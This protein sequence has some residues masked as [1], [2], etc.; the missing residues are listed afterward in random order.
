MAAVEMTGAGVLPRPPP[1]TLSRSGNA[2]ETVNSVKANI[3]K[4][5]I[6]VMM[7]YPVMEK[8]AKYTGL[9]ASGSE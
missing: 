7:I 4:I 9:P 6:L 3:K 8:I 1:W 5:R 2:G